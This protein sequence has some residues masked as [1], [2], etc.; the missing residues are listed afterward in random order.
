MCPIGLL[1]VIELASVIPI[2]NSSLPRL[3]RCVTYVDSYVDSLGIP[4]L[5]H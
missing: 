3:I 5:I 1:R 4:R 2:G